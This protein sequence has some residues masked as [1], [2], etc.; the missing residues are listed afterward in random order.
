MVT[1]PAGLAGNAGIADGTNSSAR[2]ALPIG[3]AVDSADNVYVG[4]YYGDTIRKITLSGTNGVVTTLAGLAGTLPV[5]TGREAWRGFIILPVWR[6]TVPASSMWPTQP[7]ARSGKATCPGSPAIISQPQNLIVNSGASVS[8]SVSAVETTSL[9]YQWQFNTTN[10]ADGA[11]VTGSQ[12]NV[13]SLSNVTPAD[14]GTYQVVVTNVYGS[15]NAVVLLDVVNPSVSLVAP[16]DGQSFSAP[17]TI[18]LSAT[19]VFATTN[20]TVN[21]YNGTTLLGTATTTPYDLS[22]SNVAA[23]NYAFTAVATNASGLSLTSAVAYVTVNTPG[24]ASI[25]FGSLDTS[26][27][28]P[29]TGAALAAFLAQFGISIV[30]DSPGTSVAVENQSN[31]A[32]GNSV[33]SPSQ[34]NLL[35]QIGGNGPVSFTMVFSNL[36]TAFSFTRPELLANPSVTYPAWQVQAFDSLGILLAETNAP[37]ISS[38]TNVQA[39]TYTL[40]GGG[41]ASIEFISEGTG[42]TTFNAML[43][44]GFVLT[45]GSPANLPPSVVITSPTNAQVFTNSSEIP[46]Q[47]ATAPGAGR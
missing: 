23:G 10:L 46:I 20:T 43:L 19:A 13:L 40:E 16:T 25:D 33:L 32:G 30:T 11:Q 26:G 3:V 37:Q 8:F 18:S 47:V 24:T 38:S 7:T 14:A 17:A 42:L 12:S 36:L 34:P 22:V 41:I 29:V 39:Q 21:F 35:T 6:W 5:R 4:D 27:N 1:T 45:P 15:T 44:D 31:V 9:L 2:F 28:A